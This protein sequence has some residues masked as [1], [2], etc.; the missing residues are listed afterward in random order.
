MYALLANALSYSLIARDSF[1]FLDPNPV[2]TLAPQL[3]LLSNEFALQA[4]APVLQAHSFSS[5][6][7]AWFLSPWTFQAPRD[8]RDSRCVWDVPSKCYLLG[9]H[10][11]AWHIFAKHIWL[12][13]LLQWFRWTSTLVCGWLSPVPLKSRVWDL[14]GCGPFASHCSTVMLV[15]LYAISSALQNLI[16][17]ERGKDKCLLFWEL[18]LWG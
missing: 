11:Q 6:C 4:P 5:S 3:S 2:I 9:I 15:D 12:V 17:E 14:G 18:K 1:F 13:Q 7:V 16:T 10:M 8:R